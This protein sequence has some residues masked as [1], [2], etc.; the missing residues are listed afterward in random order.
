[1]FKKSIIELL[2]IRSN[3]SDSDNIWF[4]IFSVPA[5]KKIKPFKKLGG[6]FIS[7]GTEQVQNL[8]RLQMDKARKVQFKL[9]K[10]EKRLPKKQHD[11]SDVDL[12]ANFDKV[13]KEIRSIFK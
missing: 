13:Y 4:D 5:T 10:I 12:Q 9:P 7:K 1:M 6:F 8:L 11:Y 3:F 2:I